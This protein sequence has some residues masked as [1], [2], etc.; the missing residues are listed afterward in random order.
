MTDKEIVA[1][2]RWAVMFYSCDPGDCA[3][4]ECKAVCAVAPCD[5]GEYGRYKIQTQRAAADCIERLTADVAKVTQ[6]RDAAVRDCAQFPCATCNNRNAA[7]G[8]CRDCRCEGYRRT[9]HDWRGVCD[10]NGGG[11]APTQNHR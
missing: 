2:L 1:R 11:D 9:E 3:R 5:N 8:V 6:E 7:S 10:E 4:C